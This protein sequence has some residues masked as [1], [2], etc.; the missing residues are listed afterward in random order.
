MAIAIMIVIAVHWEI[1]AKFKD[2]LEK[3]FMLIDQ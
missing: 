2:Y 1:D 3:E